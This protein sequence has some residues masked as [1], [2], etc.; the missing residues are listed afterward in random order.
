MQTG[1]STF[2]LTGRSQQLD[3]RI[4]AFRP[5][6]ADVALADRLFAA[7][8]ASPIVRFCAVPFA[9]I[10]SRPDG[11]Q[12]SELLQAEAFAVLNVT[13][14]W[15]W[16][17]SEHDH[18]VGYVASNDL[19]LEKVERPCNHMHT[20]PIA[21]ARRFLGRAY[22]W[23]GRGGAGIDCSGLVQRSFAESGFAVPRDSDLQREHFGQ[24]VDPANA[25]AGDLI[26]F[27]GHVGI[28]TANDNLIH[29]TRHHGSVVEE[30]LCDVTAR[31]LL[32]HRQGIVA[33]KRIGGSS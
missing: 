30:P 27:P 23:G 15:A 13:G 29:A 3:P 9:A 4:H 7:H 16:G 31:M 17:W 22:V 19:S 32:K 11:E 14:E 10:R 21:V 8:F 12:T 1:T 20:D 6:L 24:F 5:D 25:S 2:A 33:A 28:L 26:F 18:Y